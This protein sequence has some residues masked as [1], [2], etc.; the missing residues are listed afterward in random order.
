MERRS[1]SSCE[2]RLVI[3]PLGRRV[4][5]SVA[6]CYYRIC[7]P[8]LRQTGHSVA[9][10]AY[11]GKRWI[12]RIVPHPRSVANSSPGGKGK[13]GLHLNGLKRLSAHPVKDI[14]NGPHVALF[15][16][17]NEG[18]DDL[19]PF[20]RP[21]SAPSWRERANACRIQ[22]WNTRT[23]EGTPPLLM[24]GSLCLKGLPGPRPRL[25]AGCSVRT[26]IGFMRS[27]YTLRLIQ[28]YGTY[29]HRR[30]SERLGARGLTH[31]KPG[32]R[33]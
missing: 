16:H 15:G 24:R 5:A 2:R 26:C 13:L 31:P 11:N 14:F 17:L 18:L 20:V 30:A 25:A 7:N 23:S 19:S 9:Q 21:S 3:L 1:A 8:K 22:L 27:I 10:L 4:P 33:G 6:E 12:Q 32:V 29:T 28:S